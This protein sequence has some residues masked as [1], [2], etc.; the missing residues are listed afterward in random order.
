M[1]PSTV[2]VALQ[3][4]FPVVPALALAMAR[5]AGIAIVLPVF[6][7]AQLGG[8]IRAAFALAMALPC[9]PSA[10]AALTDMAGGVGWLILLSAKEAFAGALLGFLFGMP[11]WA[12]QGAGEI[13]DMQRS[14]TSGSAPE[15]GTGNQDSTTANLFAVSTVAIFVVT[16]GLGA[17]AESLYASYAAWPLGQVLPGAGG[18]WMA[19]L[20]GLLDRLTR[21]SLV[22]A[23]PLVLTGLLTETGV[24]LLSRAAPKFNV[25]DLS[26]TLRNLG[27]ALV[28]MLYATFLTAYAEGVLL[29]TRSVLGQF[30]LLVR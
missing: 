22:V 11:V 28:L 30:G 13:V 26:P 12:V 29:D 3:A 20:L 15:P 25:Y 6:T 18:A 1:E 16:G 7:R 27:F 24:A 17:V 9:V 14:A 19:F 21:L 5:P 23:A 2:A 10:S 8:P 4:I